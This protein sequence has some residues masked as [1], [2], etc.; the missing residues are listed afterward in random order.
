MSEN[1]SQHHQTMAAANE[2]DDADSDAGPVALEPFLHQV[3]GHFPMVTLDVDTV[4]KPLNEREHKFYRSLPR[5]LRP[6]APNFGGTMQV[7]A[8]EDDR[9]YIV[10][11]GQPPP[12][13]V[14]ARIGYSQNDS[15]CGSLSGTP[16]LQA[17]GSLAGSVSTRY[18]LRRGE[19]IEME[20][21]SLPASATAGGAATA[22]E[23]DT[24][25]ASECG[26]ADDGGGFFNPWALKCHRD[27]LKKLGLLRPASATGSPAATS[28]GGENQ[29]G[30]NSASA[31]AHRMTTTSSRTN[32]QMYLLLENLV[33]KYSRPC[34]LDLKVGARQY[35][36]DASSAKRQRKI[37]KSNSTTLATLGLRLCGMQV[38]DGLTGRYTC[39]NK[40]YGRQLNGEDFKRAIGEFFLSGSTSTDSKSRLRTD[41]V[42]KILRK[43]ISLRRV[44]QQLDSFRFYT[45]SLLLTYDGGRP[46]PALDQ[47]EEDEEDECADVRIIDFANSTHD[48]L[49]LDSSARHCGPDDGFLF[50][51]DT[52]IGVLQ[53]LPANMA[54]SGKTKLDEE[55]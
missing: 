41:M 44:I 6:F 46:E 22:E 31:L 30:D 1:E 39:R 32:P 55:P 12:Q 11:R 35:A 14:K 18:R 48:G 50:G 21:F 2:N 8:S 33:S 25:F 34:V 5:A 53:D 49:I 42:S 54:I 37:A 24:V 9:G 40:Y 47:E 15:S 27:H 10:L 4:C 23:E 52:L 28:S 43:L 16:P 26:P 45:S 20:A 51:L 36:D 19:R 7:E 29:S 3:G 13:Y 17:G 38:Y